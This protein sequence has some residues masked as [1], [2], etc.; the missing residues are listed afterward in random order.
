[1]H[2]AEAIELVIKATESHLHALDEQGFCEESDDYVVALHV[3]EE[4]VEFLREEEGHQAMREAE[5]NS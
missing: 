2:I 3:F 1:M 4:W 5:W